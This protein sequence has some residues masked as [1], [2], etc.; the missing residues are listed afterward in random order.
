MSRA[1]GRRRN[2][3]AIERTILYLRRADRLLPGD[4]ATLAIL[5]TTATALDEA[6]GAYDIAVVARVHLAALSALLAG[7][8]T[9]DDAELDRLIAAIRAP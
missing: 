5:R 2:R 3:A 8:A 6:A 7:H 1:D 9:P 4:D